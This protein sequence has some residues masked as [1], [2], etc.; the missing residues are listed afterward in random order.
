MSTILSE[1]VGYLLLIGVGVILSLSVILMV[2]A[3]TKWLGTRKTSEW[4]YTA[5]R[6]IK[7]GLIASSIVS[8]WTWA[9]TLLQSST[10]TYEFGLGGAFWYAAG[11]S[12]Q[13]ILF[14]IL[15]IELKRKA[16]MTHTFP[17]MLYVRFGKH[18]HKVFLVF[19][20][21]TN[22]IVTAM[23]LLGG[24]AVINSLTGVNITLAA[25]L[26]PA[27][28]IVYTIFGGLKAT[29]FAEYLNTSFI[30]I[31]VLIFVTSIYFINPEIGGIS[32]MYD[33]LTQASILQPVEGN[34]FG[35][36]LTLASIGALIFGVINIVGNFGT[37]FVDQSYWQKAIA[38]R[39]K[40]ATGGFIIGGLAWFA[41]PFTLATT[42]GLAAI[43]TG[44]TLSESDIGLG[45][46]APT[47]AA[48][49][50]G[51]FGAILILS[52]LFTAVTA[53]GSS[54]LVSVSS[55][56]TYDVFRTYLKPSATGRE[57]IRVSRLTILGF[58]IGMGFLT[59]LLYQ[60]GVSLQYVYLM[61]GILIGSA[62]A[63]ISFAILWK[64][65][66]R[67]VA[68][69]GAIIGLIF[70][71]SVWL[72]TANFM[73][74]E[75][76]LV[77][78]GNQ[79]PLLYGN[80]ASILTGLLITVFGSLIK[81][82]N[83]D[84]R[85]MH[86]KILVVDD[87]VRSMIKRDTD[88]QYLKR[89]LNFCIKIGFSISIFFVIVWPATFILTDFI[90]DEQSFFFWISLAI[91]WAVAAGLVLIILP[92]IEARKSIAEIIHKANVESD[93]ALV[94]SFDSNN[95]LSDNTPIIRV[96][97]P[98]DGSASSLRALHHSSYLFKGITRVRIYL[99]HVIEWTDDD[100]ENI[101]ETMSSQIQE[102]GRLILRSIVVPKQLNDY[103][104]IVK[105][106]NPSVKI[107]ELGDAL[108]VDMIIM[109]KVGIGKSNSSLGHISQQ[110]VNLTTKPVVFI[111]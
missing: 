91:V 64:K 12:I 29:F 62:V 84:F 23:L 96:L 82:E 61:M 4:F 67:I 47:T 31:V 92:F 1:N 10:V 110:V 90:F 57:L 14:A 18:P 85:I 105:L 101:D 32:G 59:L 3:E 54:Q 28:I 5:G 78:T 69:A 100:D 73:F 36:Y 26:I 108:N 71:I 76:T 109:G 24:A 41:I 17:E 63:P 68:T 22:T 107:V 103:K 39:P 80:I 7:T 102:E 25:F 44:V 106:G 93:I 79:I 45:L 11:A 6:T 87:K 70:G 81:S 21:M 9:A 89:S 19:G 42:L 50:M 77:S 60:S 53:A 30:F 55:L 86:Q 104:R 33:K 48:H 99:L 2:K 27:C 20:L 75:I 94:N 95:D 49:L 51:D 8:A 56:V 66:H 35:T 98:V 88:E 37:V 38:A 74:G 34:A 111:D 65:T 52:I 40:A 83:F 13:V 97:V 58:G 46:I 15:A 43:A 72:F 16:P